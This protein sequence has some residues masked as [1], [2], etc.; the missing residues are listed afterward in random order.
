MSD[1][2]VSSARKE[3]LLDRIRRMTTDDTI[4][5]DVIQQACGVPLQEKVRITEGFSNEVYAVTTRDGQ[6]VI[7]RIHWYES[8]YFESEQWALARCAQH[9]LPT[10][11]ILLVQHHMPGGTPRSI[12][13]ETRLEGVTLRSFLTAET[14]PQDQARR[15]LSEAGG[16]LARVH[17]VPTV[18]FGRIN[19]LGVALAPSWEAYIR[20]TSP[21]L[22][23]RAAQNVGIVAQD[24]TDACRLSQEYQRMWAHTQPC[25]LHGDLS[26]QHLM[27]HQDHI[28]GM[29]DFEFPESGDP[30]MDL[31]YWGYWDAFHGSSFPVEWLLEGYHQHT[32]ID[33][34]FRLRLA[35]SRLQLSLDKLSYHGVRDYGSPGMREFLQTSFQRD[36]KAIRDHV[37]YWRPHE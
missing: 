28:S 20:R 21:D 36:L 5:A 2:P 4:I 7:V 19:A 32:P 8:P 9:D 35:G 1:E 6:R 12:C 24:V 16:L 27:V 17:T 14:R 3:Y 25:L 23:R 18:G 34:A 15:L 37:A 13:V 31:A 29:I 33:A 22:I 26:L 10:P 11:R 30:A